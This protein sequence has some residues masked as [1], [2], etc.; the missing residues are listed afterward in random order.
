[1]VQGNLKIHSENILPIIKKWLYS[2]KDIFVRELISNACDASSKL[3]ILQ[4]Q[5][6]I[7][8]DETPLEI[9][10]FI[11]KDKKTLTF[12]DRGIGMDHEEVEKY[13]AQLAFSGAEEFLEKYKSDKPEDQ[14]IGHFGLGFYSAFMV[15]KKVEIETLSYKEGAKPVF[16]SSDGSSTYEIDR[17]SRVERGT[18]IT[19]Y[20]SEEEAEY[21]DPSRIRGILEKY[22]AFLPHPILLDASS[23]NE[24]PPLWI[25]P[26]SEITDQEYIDFYHKLYP[27]EP[28]PLFWVHLNVDYPF[29]LKGI[30]YFPKLSKDVDIK[31]ET[32]K[33]FCNRVFVSNDCNDILPAYLTILRGA[34]DS[35]DIPLNVSRSTLQLDRTVRQLGNHISKKISDKLSTFYRTDQKKFHACWED[36]E[37]IIKYGA[38]QEDKFYERVKEFLIFKNDRGEFTTIE[39]YLTRN[40]E[41]TNNTV[42]YAHEEH[43]QASFLQLYQRKGIEV[44]F[45]RPMM[46]DQALVQ[47]LEQKHSTNFKR[48]DADVSENLLDPSREKTLLDAEGKTERVRIAEFFKAKLHEENLDVEAKS[49]A[50]DELPTFLMIKE[51]ERRMREMFAHHGKGDMPNLVKPTFVVNTNNRLIQSIF[52]MRDTHPE[53]AK[54][55]VRHVYDTAR[56]AGKELNQK[57][58]GDYLNR[59]T[60]IL[61]ALSS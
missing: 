45:S 26:S 34:I 49:L 60:K 29:N 61:E 23:I 56:L 39:D 41:K 17:G 10:V 9:K 27:F 51:Q 18:Q 50:S 57:Q 36:I 3:Q 46:I 8:K 33:L 1:M 4:D 2:D 14:I 54:D 58:L 30:L 20:L 55:M 21:L 47:L 52:K 44:I 40:K 13:I 11:D 31:K 35:P 16:W 53:L 22:C 38:L 12:S 24:T 15:A 37:I 25:R 19:L 7:K 59:S 48:I 43:S 6:I 42:F 28:A 32:I 5:E